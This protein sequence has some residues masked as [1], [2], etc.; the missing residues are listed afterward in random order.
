[1]SLA[2]C[3]AAA[4]L[5]VWSRRHVGGIDLGLPRSGYSLCSLG[6]AIYTGGYRGHFLDASAGS[7]TRSG[8]IASENARRCASAADM[9]FARR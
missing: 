8:E 3:R 4:V 1:M 9:I 2:L 5:W 6:G 7:S